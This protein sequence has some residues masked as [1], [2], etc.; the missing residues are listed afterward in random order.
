MAHQCHFKSVEKK[1]GSPKIF[2]FFKSKESFVQWQGSIDVKGALWNI[3]NNTCNN[4]TDA[5]W[6][7]YEILRKSKLWLK[8][9][10]RKLIIAVCPWFSRY[11]FVLVFYD[12][13]FSFP[14]V[15]VFVCKCTIMM[16]VGGWHRPKRWAPARNQRDGTSQALIPS[17]HPPTRLNHLQT[18]TWK[19][20]AITYTTMVWDL[21]C[22]NLN[23]SS[24]SLHT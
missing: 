11:L 3:N 9:V 5:Q 24:D 7:G 2:F 1:F 22:S 17:T 8:T 15:N 6:C 21:V 18:H 19:Q 4:T 23:S 12:A 20:P 10:Y 16:D 14:R 13:V